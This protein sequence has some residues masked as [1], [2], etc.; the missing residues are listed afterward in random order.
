MEIIALYLKLRKSRIFNQFFLKIDCSQEPSY[1]TF[2]LFGCFWSDF[3]VTV[4][5]SSG[6]SLFQ[7]S[8]RSNASGEQARHAQVDDAFSTQYISG[9]VL[10]KSIEGCL[11][12]RKTLKRYVFPE[13]WTSQPKFWPRFSG[14]KTFFPLF[15]QQGPSRILSG[16]SGVHKSLLILLDCWTF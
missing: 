8:G 10:L 13:K 6:P 4:L 15:E 12:M 1:P 2:Q 11:N 14:L 16:S 7:E 5:N 9:R 3:F